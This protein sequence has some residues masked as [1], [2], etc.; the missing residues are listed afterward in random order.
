MAELRFA[1]VLIVGALFLDAGIAKLRLG[2][3]RTELADYQLVPGR[4][5]P[6]VARALPVV[7]AAAGLALLVGVA[8]RPV[9]VLLAPLLLAFSAGMVV[10]LMRGRRI[11]CGCRGS[12]HPIS[13]PLASWNV[14]LAAAAVGTAA[15]GAPPGLRALVSAWPGLSPG[16]ALATVT[17]LVLIG[18][19]A[20]VVSLG[21]RLRRRMDTFSAPHLSAGTS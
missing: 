10:N 3:F 6:A 12:A 18:V 21:S 20:R 8:T 15:S 11:S 16:D 13:W 5:L 9:L 7:E 19:A 2:R 14:A 1:V 4:L 17:S